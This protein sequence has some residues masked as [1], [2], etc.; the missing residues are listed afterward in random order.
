MNRECCLRWV[1]LYASVI[2]LSPS[3]LVAGTNSYPWMNKTIVLNSTEH[4]QFFE[5]TSHHTESWTFKDGQKINVTSQSF[6]TETHTASFETAETHPRVMK[7]STLRILNEEWTPDKNW[8]VLNDIASQITNA[9]GLSLDVR[10]SKTNYVLRLNPTEPALTSEL[11]MLDLLREGKP[12]I[13]LNLEAQPNRS[14]VYYFGRSFI[15]P[16]DK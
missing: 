1:L 7:S 12:L 4:Y 2:L 16:E 8:K 11:Y 14:N 15:A 5:Q 3:M 6:T 13:S 9:M 10:T